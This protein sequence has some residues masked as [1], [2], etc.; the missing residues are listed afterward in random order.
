M[1]TIEHPA[2]IKCLLTKV[3]PEWSDFPI[4]RRVPQQNLDN[5]LFAQ[6]GQFLNGTMQDPNTL[7]VH[8]FAGGQ[9]QEVRGPSIVYG[10]NSRNS[11]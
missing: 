3:D 4:F 11:A 5:Y 6:N 1:K 8:M 2:M 7:E 9:W 10:M